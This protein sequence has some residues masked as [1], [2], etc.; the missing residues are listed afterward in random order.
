MGPI[1]KGGDNV[2]KSILITGGAGYIGSHAVIAFLEADFNVVVLDDLST[3]VRKSVATNAE[4]IEGNAGDEALVGQIIQDH[5]IEGVI[6]FAGSLIVPESVTDPLK[7]YRNNTCVSRNLIET[8]VRTGV[9]RFVFSSTAAVYGISEHVPV[10]EDVATLPI[11]PYGWSKLMT[12]LILKDAAAAHPFSYMALRYFNVAG[13]DPGGRV[14]QSTPGATNL[15]KVACEVAAGTRDCLD[16]FGDDYDTP[17]GT[18][19]RDYIHV[20]D[21]VNAHVDAYRGLEKDGQSAVL[22]CGY[23]HGY[24][25]RDVVAAVESETGTSL[26]VAVAPRRAGDP[27]EMTADSTK[28]RE[29]Y[30]WQPRYDDL[31][32]I[33]RTALDWE[34][35]LTK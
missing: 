3:G 17:D 26:S 32:F 16:I 30:G 20:T 13:A 31:H 21:L 5:D 34:R 23:G 22:N 2:S 15:I 27:A 4:F 19:V 24:S 28:V 14:G 9:G 10:T 33:V 11:N 7:Y 35:G 18:G 8:C 29:N 12:E 1:A 6:H 25:V